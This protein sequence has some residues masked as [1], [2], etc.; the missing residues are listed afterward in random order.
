LLTKPARRR[1]QLECA[2]VGF[3]IPDEF[4]VGYGLDLA[5]RFRTLEYIGTLRPEAAAALVEGDGSLP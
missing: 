4:V 5:E 3:E 2:Y 1:I